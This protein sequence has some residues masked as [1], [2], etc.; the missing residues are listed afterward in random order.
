MPSAASIREEGAE[1]P[2][3]LEPADEIRAAGLDGADWTIELAE[4]RTREGTTR[5]GAPHV[6]EDAIVLARRA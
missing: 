5:E 2:A 6:F 1:P 3:R 4:I